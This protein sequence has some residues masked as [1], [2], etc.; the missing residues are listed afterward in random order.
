MLQSNT[1]YIDD[2]LLSFEWLTRLI[3][4]LMLAY[5]RSFHKERTPPGYF[6][7]ESVSSTRFFVVSIYEKDSIPQIICSLKSGWAR[8]I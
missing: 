2:L 3:Q 4:I 8:L 1:S 5:L 6:A 7:G